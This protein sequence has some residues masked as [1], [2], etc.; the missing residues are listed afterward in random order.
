MPNIEKMAST[1]KEG[2]PIFSVQCPFCNKC[3]SVRRGRGAVHLRYHECEGLYCEI[4][5]KFCLIDIPCAI[6]VPSFC[7]R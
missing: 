3:F 1:M 2:N 7:V 6:A 5:C 4:Q